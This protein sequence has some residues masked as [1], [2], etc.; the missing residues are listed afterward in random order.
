MCSKLRGVQFLNSPEGQL[1]FTCD[2]LGGLYAS[3]KTKQ[4]AK[5]I[6]KVGSTVMNQEIIINKMRTNH[7]KEENNIAQVNFE[8]KYTFEE[9]DCSHIIDDLIKK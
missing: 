5:L 2:S 4:E 3:V 8:Q 6:D 9:V 1:V 7:A